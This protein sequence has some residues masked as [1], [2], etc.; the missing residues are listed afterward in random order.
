MAAHQLASRSLRPV[1][2]QSSLKTFALTRMRHTF[3]TSAVSMGAVSDA[4]QHDHREL[5]EYCDNILNATDVE[6]RIGWQNKFTWELAR[7]SIAEELV[8]YPAM[9]KHVPN[10]TAMAEKDRKE[11][12]AVNA[13]VSICLHLNASGRSSYKGE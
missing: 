6:R 4:I 5:E 9:E 8:I 13:V 10:G 12:Y 3:S 7:H 11:H 2:V 1:F